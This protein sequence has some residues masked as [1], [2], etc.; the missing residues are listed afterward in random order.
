MTATRIFKRLWQL[1][2]AYVVLF[3]VYIELIGYVARKSSASALID[4]FNVT[5]IV[6]HT[7]RTLIYGLLLQAKPLNLEV[8]QLFI[9]LIALFPLVLLGMMRRR[10]SRWRCR[11]R[12]TSPPVISTGTCLHFPTDAGP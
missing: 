3:V 2:V 11:S 4:E 12:S 6:D 9:V 8:L 10:I 7:I 5:G 1:Y